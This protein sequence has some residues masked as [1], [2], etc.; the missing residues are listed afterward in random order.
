M[1]KAEAGYSLHYGNAE[2]PL[3]KIVP[4]SCWPDMW[5]I[6]WPDGQL[7]DMVN[8]SR[9]KD[10]AAVL[11]ERGPPAKD[12]RRLSWRVITPLGEAL[13]ASHSEVESLEAPD[14]LPDES[15]SPATNLVAVA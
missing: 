5:R 14:C 6:A 10:A 3:A 7:S 1:N 13:A 2:R 8:L 4:D 9:A 12:Q 15:M 11:A